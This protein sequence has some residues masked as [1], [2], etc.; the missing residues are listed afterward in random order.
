MR[1]T[2]TGER[3][4][5]LHKPALGGEKHNH[6]CLKTRAFFDSRNEEKRQN[7][8]RVAPADKIRSPERKDFPK[9]R[10]LRWE[11]SRLRL[12][13][14]VSKIRAQKRKDIKNGKDGRGNVQGVARGDK[15]ERVQGTITRSVAVGGNPATAVGKR[16]KSVGISNWTRNLFLALDSCLPAVSGSCFA[17]SSL[18]W[19]F[20]QVTSRDA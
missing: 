4:R 9:K 18:K 1:V 17:I 6:D 7:R 16:G 13:P 2:T 20:T 5:S 8:T 12:A 11:E 15:R 14:A 10:S 19:R 3:T